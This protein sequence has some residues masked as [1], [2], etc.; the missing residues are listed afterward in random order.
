EIWAAARDANAEG[1]LRALPQGLDT[2]MGEGGARLSGG[3]R[4]RIAMV[5]Q[6]VVIFAASAR[7]N[8]RYGNWDASEDEIWAAARDANAET[9]LVNLSLPINANIADGQG[10]GTIVD[11]ERNGKFSCRASALRLGSNEPTVANP[12]NSPCQDD[13]KTAVSANLTSGSVNVS[14]STLNA[15]TDQTPNDLEATAPAPTDNG[16]AVAS[17]E[18]ATTTALGLVTI[19]ATAVQS[20]AR[21]QCTAG[22]G[23][24]TPAFT[25]SSTIASLTVN[26][27][28]VNVLGNAV[29]N[30]PLG[31]GTVQVNRKVTTA[32]SVTQQAVRIILLGQEIVIAEAKANFSG[33][34]CSQ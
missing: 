29:V 11:D 9:F 18:R 3:Q 28:S 22:P 20:Q 23:G 33:N 17:V 2:F 21:V 8:L 27:V 13:A 7:D 12:A 10:V 16:L 6:E 24:L 19:R 4:Q 32:T 31:L 30:L 1:F 25:S 34:P 5:P 14:S 15:N 26:G